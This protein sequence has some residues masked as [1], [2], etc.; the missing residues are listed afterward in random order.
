MVLASRNLR[1]RFTTHPVTT[2]VSAALAI[3]TFILA[4]GLIVTG[5]AFILEGIAPSAA[6]VLYPASLVSNLWIVGGTM[7]WLGFLI[8]KAGIRLVSDLTEAP[9]R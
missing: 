8:G 5:F 3:V 2:L 4:G 7:V 9:R 6:G 1:A